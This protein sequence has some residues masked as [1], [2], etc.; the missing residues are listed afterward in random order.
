MSLPPS[1]SSVRLHII[2]QQLE[3]AGWSVNR[4]NLQ[5]EFRLPSP[6]R[7][8]AE[9]PQ[10]YNVAA[11]FADYA[12]LGRDEKPLA[13]VEVKRTSRDAY[14]GKR[15]AGDYADRVKALYGVEPFIFLCNGNSILFWSRPQAAPRAVSGF[16]TI[17]DL[18]RLA[19][20]R[21]YRQLL[22]KI[23]PKPPIVDRP[24]QL[25]CY[26]AETLSYVPR[27]WVLIR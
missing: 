3:R 25:V 17:E 6:Q 1:E 9:A 16:F 24:Y 27:G 20:Q 5:K 8:L 15:Q 26:R 12:L 7:H 4:G 14:A 11:E 23:G 18:E 22:G 2:D 13:I 21:R 19:F 10:H